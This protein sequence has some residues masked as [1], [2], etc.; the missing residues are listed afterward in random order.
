MSRLESSVSRF[1][2]VKNEASLLARKTVEELRE[3]RQFKDSSRRRDLFGKGLM[4]L[5]TLATPAEYRVEMMDTSAEWR[6]R[7]DGV[8]IVVPTRLSLIGCVFPRDTVFNHFVSE[9]ANNHRHRST[10]PVVLTSTTMSTF[11]DTYKMPVQGYRENQRVLSPFAEHNVLDRIQHGG[12]IIVNNRLRLL[13]YDELFHEVR[14]PSDPEGILIQAEWYVDSNNQRRVNARRNLHRRD[15]FNSIGQIETTEGPITFS[16]NTG[17]DDN[18][19]YPPRHRY[20]SIA[21]MI[22]LANSI[23]DTLGGDSWRLCGLEYHN[24]GTFFRGTS[25]YSIICRQNPYFAAYPPGQKASVRA[26]P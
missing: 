11:S 13:S 8:V 21:E 5:Q 15:S 16:L 9:A 19:S 1:H 4:H 3:W 25:Y 10:P 24:G 6:K 12:I 2:S 18:S 20:T 7:K 14:S 23:T 17:F 26:T 22:A